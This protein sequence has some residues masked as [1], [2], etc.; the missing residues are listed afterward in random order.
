MVLARQRVLAV[1]QSLI[2]VALMVPGVALAGWLGWFGDQSTL[3]VVVACIPAVLGG[4]FPLQLWLAGGDLQRRLSARVF[5]QVVVCLTPA[6][7]VPGWGPVMVIA[8]VIT[9][10]A[11]M[12]WS[13][14]R[15]W[16]PVALWTAV[17][18]AL[19]QIG[20]ALGI[21]PNNLGEPA[22]TVLWV[23]T[24][25]ISLM[26]IWQLGL[27]FELREGAEAATRSG[28]R[29]LK[30]LVQ[31]SND[32][33]SI[34]GIDGVVKYV[35][36]SIET[37]LGYRPADLVGGDARFGV[38]PRD[39]KVAQDLGLRA[40]AHPDTAQIGEMRLLHADGTEHWHSVTMRSLTDDPD[41][42]GLVI[43]Q[44]DICESRKLRESLAHDATHDSLTGLCNR[45]A[46]H[47]IL[48]DSLALRASNQEGDSGLA[49]LFVDLDGFKPVNDRYGHDNG[50]VLLIE[51]AHLLQRNVPDTDTVAR[52]G[53][54]EFAIVLGGVSTEVDAVAVAQRII[55]ALEV[56]LSLPKADVVVGASIGIA[57]ADETSSAS[58]LLRRADHAMY[59]AKR[60]GRNGWA[61]H[62]AESDEPLQALTAR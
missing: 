56:P 59:R 50:D 21:V 10:T 47:R 54:D 49:V 41:I 33:V 34:I 52:I 5:L 11:Q 7:Y 55:T 39:F 44:R 13:G 48:E 12:R 42:Q 2:G 17:G 60:A 22:S 8:Y 53:G 35:S 27:A 31:G 30:A 29:R 38:D 61:V 24:L 15:A 51:V 43:N 40:M 16:R 58:D 25:G 18:S 57:L 32:I 46:L 4:H 37:Q 23:L 62:P 9:G 45:S 36:E 1:L 3:V 6:V 26:L 28:E 19:G 14:A 20:I